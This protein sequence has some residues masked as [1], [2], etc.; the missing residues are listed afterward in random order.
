MTGSGAGTGP[1][2][3]SIWLP[4]TQ[5]GLEPPPLLASSTDGVRIHLA[6]GRCLLDGT[7]SWWT[8]CHGYNHPHIV[9][10]L[11]SQAARMPH[12]M[13]GGL[14]H[15]G[16]LRLAE[17]L[18]RIAPGRLSR[19]FFSD[20]GSTAV[21]VALKLAIQAA[22]N[23]GE[24][25]RTRI[26]SFRGAYH[27]DT[28]GAMS[29]A[30]P[31]EGFHRVF[32]HALPRQVLADLPRD[33]ASHAAYAALL[34]RE[35]PGLAA[36]IVEPLVQGG[37]GMIFHDTATLQRVAGEA[38]SRGIALIADEV[39]TGFGRTGSLFACTRAGV[40]PDL[41]CL[42]KALTGG[43]IGLGATLA[44]PSIF[45]AFLSDSL[46]DAFMHGP[47][48]M[49]NPLACA[50]ANASLDLFETEPRLE[51]VAAISARLRHGL[52]NARTLPGIRDVRVLG[53][54]GVIELESVPVARLYALRRALI[55][56]GLWVRPFG[57]ILYVTPAFII[58]PDDLDTLMAGMIAALVDTALLD[59][60]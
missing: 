35:G 60:A 28:M 8:A 36:V 26:L 5:M 41:L 34:D 59:T 27:G 3:S 7:A 48:Y 37:G 38:Q 43:A 2:L 11:R 40:E 57:R 53:A 49:A 46:D 47:T 9:D 29:V 14:V 12:L 10:S 45:E 16:A 55:A 39:F 51:Q 21:E 30:D 1:D 54:I 52:E 6:D 32:N 31:E 13:F 33:E 23:R 56:R 20:S 44:S 22:R 24:P 50:A 17:R 42:S 15:E 18:T 25:E 4:Y 19:V 58:R